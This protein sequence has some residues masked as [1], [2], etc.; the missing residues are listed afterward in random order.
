MYRAKITK[1]IS[2]QEMLA[3][4]AQGMSV[5]QIAEACDCC[6][7]TVYRYIGGDRN[8]PPA[9]PVVTYN[10][11]DAKEE[12]M[13]EVAEN[14]MQEECAIL[15]E[16][17]KAKVGETVFDVSINRENEK[18]EIA[19]SSDSILIVAPISEVEALYKVMGNVMSR[20]K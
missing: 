20:I 18:I 8:L 14:K 5:A 9:P 13:E 16:R 11:N 19:A 7:A 17:F 4:R 2:R 15:S 1:D 10:I 12:K 3:L 6:R